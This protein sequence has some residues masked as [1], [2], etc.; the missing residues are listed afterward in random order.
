M[1]SMKKY[2]NILLHTIFTGNTGP[3]KGETNADARK[4]TARLV[5]KTKL[6]SGLRSGV[7]VAAAIAAVVARDVPS[8]ASALSFDNLLELLRLVVVRL[9]LCLVFYIPL[10]EKGQLPLH[11]YIDEPVVGHSA[12]VFP[13]LHGNIGQGWLVELIS[14]GD[15]LG[16]DIFKQLRHTFA[17]FPVAFLDSLGRVV[18]ELPNSFLF[19]FLLNEG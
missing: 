9:Q 10:L 11:P 16:F 7:R 19:S 17:P 1:E 15:L 2:I 14:W 4:T 18:P 12:W 6:S 3:L 5:Q 13:L 8:L